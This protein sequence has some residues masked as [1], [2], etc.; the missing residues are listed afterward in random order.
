MTFKDFE[1]ELKLVAER[2]N[3]TFKLLDSEQSNQPEPPAEIKVETLFEKT[4]KKLILK[5]RDG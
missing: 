1:K 3:N 4:F 2:I 5:K